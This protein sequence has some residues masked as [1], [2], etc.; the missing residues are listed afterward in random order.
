MAGRGRRRLGRSLR[1]LIDTIT[2]LQQRGVGFRSLQEQ[3]DTTTPSGKLIFHIFGAMSSKVR[4][5]WSIRSALGPRNGPA[6]LS[7]SDADR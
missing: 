3:I 5:P 6:R 2:D 1:H 7:G 4:W